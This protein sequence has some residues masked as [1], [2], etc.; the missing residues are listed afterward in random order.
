MSVPTIPE[1]IEPT[2]MADYLEV[3]TRAVFQ[4]GVSWKQIANTWEAYRDA[5]AGFDPAVVARFDDGDVE[6]ILATPGVLRVARKVRATIA[7]AAALLE[8][9]AAFGSFSA[10]L[11]S[12]SSYDAASAGI[13]KRFSFVGDMNVW[14]ILFRT[15]H[16]VPHFEKWVVTIPGT[17][18]RMREMVDLARSQGR[19]PE[20]EP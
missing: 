10:Y 7:N 11:D 6:R 16:R 18:P 3:I 13:R 9:E 14:Y 4:A 5:F 2:G 17:H 15:G 19:S 8:I 12:F 1:V 20:A